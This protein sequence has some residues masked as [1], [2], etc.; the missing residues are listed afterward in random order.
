MNKYFCICILAAVIASCR[1]GHPG[2]QKTGSSTPADT[3]VIESI[4]EDSSDIWQRELQGLV[5]LY[6]EAEP[7]QTTSPMSQWCRVDIDGDSIDEV[8]I[9]SAD[10]R[11]GAFFTVNGEPSLICT[12]SPKLR[13]KL[14]TGRIRISEA[15]G[16]SGFRYANYVIK[17]SLLAHTF[18][19]F[20]VYG[21]MR[22]CTLDGKKL[23]YND[24]HNFQESLSREELSVLSLEWYPIE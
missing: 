9:R 1:G 6:G 15:E 11:Y 22:E 20:E 16:R 19:K 18:I 10:N 7:E 24:C 21:E 12:E 3:I 4:E 23:Y 8:W 13:A 14:F 17:N 5:R 2:V